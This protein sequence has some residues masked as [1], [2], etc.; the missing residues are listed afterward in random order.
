MSAVCGKCGECGKCISGVVYACLCFVSVCIRIMVCVWYMALM[1][2]VM[3]LQP[4][5]KEQVRKYIARKLQPQPVK[6]RADVEMTC[7]EYDGVERIK[8]AMRVAMQSG[9]TDVQVSKQGLVVVLGNTCG[10]VHAW[11]V[12]KDAACYNICCGCVRG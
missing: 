6:I 12:A 9:T 7:Y 1:L 11:W 8:E 4:D 3:L 2:A 10:R 5:V